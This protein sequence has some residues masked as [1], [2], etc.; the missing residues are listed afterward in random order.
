MRFVRWLPWQMQFIFWLMKYPFRFG[1]LRRGHWPRWSNLWIYFIYNNSN[2]FH[3]FRMLGWQCVIAPT[4]LTPVQI[5][6]HCCRNI[7]KCIVPG[8]GNGD[9]LCH[10]V[11][12]ASIGLTS[13]N[14]REVKWFKAVAR[15]YG[16]VILLDW[17]KVYIRVSGAHSPFD[18]NKINQ[19]RQSD[20]DDAISFHYIN[21]RIGRERERYTLRCPTS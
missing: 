21:S 15:F 10:R 7:C 8:F 4:Q 17:Q 3:G 9:C 19:L 2:W 6:K 13:R 18:H 5:Q 12:C 16:S 1:W 11:R 20:N 14:I